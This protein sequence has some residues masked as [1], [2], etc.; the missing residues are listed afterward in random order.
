MPPLQDVLNMRPG[1]MP[2][3]KSSARDGLTFALHPIGIRSQRLVIR[4]DQN[5]DVW[6][7]IQFESN[8]AQRDKS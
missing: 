1:P 5:G 8:E 2:E 3:I 4:C 7:S 6:M